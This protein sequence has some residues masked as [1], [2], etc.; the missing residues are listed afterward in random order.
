[1]GK[2]LVALSVAVLLASLLALTSCGAGPVETTTSL[3]NTATTNNA[4][5]GTTVSQ[6]GTVMAA[7]D[8]ARQTATATKAD[9]LSAASAMDAFGADLYGVLANTPATATSSSRPP[10]SRPRWP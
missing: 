2:Y 1:M 7:S 6:G 3:S 10:A 4:T 5:D 9:I 8:V